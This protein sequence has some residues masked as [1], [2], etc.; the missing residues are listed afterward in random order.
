MSIASE[1]AWQATGFDRIIFDRIMKTGVLDFFK[2]M[3]PFMILP[4]LRMG[5]GMFET[6]SVGFHL[7]NVSR[8][9]KS[10]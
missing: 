8:L 1:A 9:S 10:G 5:P 2:M 3:L 4:I 6:V 7:G